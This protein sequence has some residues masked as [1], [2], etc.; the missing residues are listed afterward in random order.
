MLVGQMN[1]RHNINSIRADG[2]NQGDRGIAQESDCRK[3][4]AN[5]PENLSC[6]GAYQPTLVHKKNNWEMENNFRPISGDR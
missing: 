1:L 2:Y 5:P 6:T 4:V 3:E